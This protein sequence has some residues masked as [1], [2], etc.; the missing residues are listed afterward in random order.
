MLVLEA[1]KVPALLDPGMTFI[2]TKKKK[3][4]LFLYGLF[5]SSSYILFH[6]VMGGID[7][8]KG[9]WVYPKGGMG[10]VSEAIAKCAAH[11]GA[12]IFTNQ[13]KSLQDLNITLLI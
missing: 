12:H 8:Y 13:V 1:F 5:F 4:P 2:F 6:H 11:Y 10:S 3:N 7:Q 9:A